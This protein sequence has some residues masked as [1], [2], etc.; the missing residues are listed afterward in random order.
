MYIEKS[1]R[2]LGTIKLFFMNRVRF[3]YLIVCNILI[4]LLSSYQLAAQPDNRI[5]VAGQNIFMSGGNVAWVNYARDIGPVPTN[6]TQFESIFEEVSLYGGNTMRLWLHTN[7]TSTPEWDGAFVVGPGQNAINDLKNILDLAQQYNINLKLC[8]WSFDM[9]QGEGTQTGLTQYQINRNTALLTEPD[10]LQAYINNALIPMVEA[11]KGHPALGA[12]E[13]FNEPEGMTSYG[14]TPNK[15]DMS[16]IQWFVNRTAGAI[17]RTDPGTPVTNG[18]WNIRVM[19]DIGSFHNYYRDDRLI[20][21]GDDPDG[22]LDFYSVHYYARHFGEDQS[23]FHNH[24]SHWELD[25]PIVVAEFW[26]TDQRGIAAEDLYTTLYDRGYAGALAWSWSDN[27]EPWQPALDNMAALR[28]HAPEAVYF[29]ISDRVSARLTAFPERIRL[30]ETSELSWITS[31]AETVEL[32]GEE[33]GLIGTMQVSPPDTTIY[34]LIATGEEGRADTARVTVYVVSEE[35]YNQAFGKPTYASSVDSPTRPPENATDGDS[36][37][38][39]SSAYGPSASYDREWIYIDLLQS[40]DI[41]RVV[42]DWEAA[43]G[44]GYNIDVS[45]DAVVWRTV[46]EER[47]GEG[48]IEEILLD[49]PAPGRYIR[50]QGVSRGTQW[51]Y[52]LWE[53][54]VYGLPSVVQPPQITLLHPVDGQRF[55]TGTDIW[56][57]AEPEQGTHPTGMV[58]FLIDGEPV[59]ETGEEPWQYR[60]SAGEP[61]EYV[62]SAKVT[63]QEFEVYSQPARIIVQ[64]LPETVWY[65]VTDADWSGTVDLY[66][67]TTVYN[68]TYVRLGSDGRLRWSELE[69]ANA[70]YYDLRI[71]YRLGDQRPANMRLQRL[72]VIN[73]ALSLDGEPD[74]WLFKEVQDVYFRKGM[75]LLNL[76]N[77]DSEVDI[78]Y[79]SVR[80]EGQ[81]PT[82]AEQPGTEQEGSENPETFTLMQN[83]PNPFNPLTIITYQLPEA[84]HVKLEVYDMLGRLV[85]ILVN[86]QKQAGTY[87]VTFNASSL[88]S[89]VYLY[90]ISMGEI[91]QTRRMMLVN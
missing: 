6:L 64:P 52:S 68:G 31:G 71:G 51:G 89:G 34:T 32:N 76:S 45:H 84:S 55:D 90:R 9:L 22:I 25:K 8:L 23:P 63:D 24:A 86:E 43:Y 67:D 7:G 65:D 88:S 4:L 44:S 27:S 17:R 74:I 81:L 16:D 56:F 14:W 50:M 12:W 10:K 75:N 79:L 49:E 26:P 19:S 61:E 37:T 11:V 78:A 38:R 30:G 83:Y 91:S 36:S 59:D 87:S 2:I 69:V 40:H 3:F 46:H 53:F 60:W 80:G 35:A 70:G 85:K 57:V 58:Q 21:A 66:S 33:V 47:N 73:V 15:V 28:N 82:S 20:A 29:S 1:N 5:E 62:I 77:V 42:L 18:S 39:W 41:S 54:E 13:I 72:P 48:G